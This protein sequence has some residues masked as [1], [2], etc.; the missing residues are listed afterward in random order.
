MIKCNF[1]PEEKRRP[2]ILVYLQESR[3]HEYVKNGLATCRWPL[4]AASLIMCRR[5][6]NQAYQVQTEI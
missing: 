4:L 1:R 3:I 2:S 5:Q 6:M